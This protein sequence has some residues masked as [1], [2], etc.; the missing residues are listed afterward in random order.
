MNELSELSMITGKIHTIRGVQV[1]LDSDLARLYQVETFNLNKAVKRNIE[2]FPDNFCFKLT[3]EEF[4][5]LT[6]QIGIPNMRG[7]RRYSPYVFTEQGVA[8]LAGVL[9]SE[10]AVRISIA[11]MNAFVAMRHYLADNAMVFKRLDCLELKGLET[12][13]NFRWIFKQ[14]ETPKQANAV[15][16]FKGQM[17]DAVS[18]I[19]E[20]ISKAEASI[21]LID[22]YVDKRTLD[23][24]SKKN[25]VSSVKIYTNR[26]NC[27]LTETEIN[28]FCSQY[29]H[30]EIRY[31]DEFHDRF[32]IL[33]S[34]E[35]YSYRSINQGC[36]KKG[37]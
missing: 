20:I 35:L 4:S 1:M 13:E 33:D 29:G 28:A 21:I 12:D 36:R 8:M 10:S 11:I 5:D 26:N 3:D 27:R 2:R 25:Q 17:W 34:K 15:I 37:F 18:C 31:S 23:M 22:G 24:L 16:F 30:L 6:F 7:G 32:L 9:H 14:L 19:E